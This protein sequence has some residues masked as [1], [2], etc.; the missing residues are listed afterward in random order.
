MSGNDTPFKIKSDKIDAP[1]IQDNVLVKA[2]K[3]MTPSPRGRVHVRKHRHFDAG[4][5]SDV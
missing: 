2:S 3:G 1:L 4:I 5:Q